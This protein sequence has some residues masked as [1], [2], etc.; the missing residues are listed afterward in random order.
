VGNVL[1]AGGA[2]CRCGRLWHSRRKGGWPADDRCADVRRGTRG[3]RWRFA[4]PHQVKV[5]DAAASGTGNELCS[6]GSPQALIGGKSEIPIPHS[7]AA[8]FKANSNAGIEVTVDGTVGGRS[9]VG[10][11]PRS[12]RARVE[13][14]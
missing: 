4:D 5:W 8:G 6:S 14:L 13:R 3:W 12:A 2:D 1:D 7:C 10:A 11:V 9:K